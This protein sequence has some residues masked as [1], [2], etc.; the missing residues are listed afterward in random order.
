[1]GVMNQIPV[2]GRF[3]VDERFLR[4]IGQLRICFLSFFSGKTIR[5]EFFRL[6]ISVKGPFFGGSLGS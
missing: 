2:Q 4:D 5:A 3:E 6:D 1:M